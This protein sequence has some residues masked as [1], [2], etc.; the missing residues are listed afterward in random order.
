MKHKKVVI[1]EYKY[2]PYSKE[3]VEITRHEYLE[4]KHYYRSKKNKKT[5]LINK[6]DISW[7]ELTYVRLVNDNFISMYSLEYDLEKFKSKLKQWLDDELNA[8]Y[9]QI[10]NTKELKGKIDFL[11]FDDF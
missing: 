1:Y 3:N 7:N 2:R 10:N 11:T 5:I 4:F 8:M 9:E 6:N